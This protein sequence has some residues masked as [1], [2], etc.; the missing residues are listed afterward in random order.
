[1]SE[2]TLTLSC[3]L[4]EQSHE[5]DIETPEGWV[6]RYDGIDDEKAFC[7]KHSVI[8]EFS[9]SNCRGCVGGWGDCDMFRS[10][11]YLYDR[12]ITKDELTTV[13]SGV[14]P[15][16]TN[17]TFSVSSGEVAEIDLSETGTT[18][19]GKAFANA[20]REYMEKYPISDNP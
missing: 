20:I 12:D 4:C 7:P 11:A 15:R 14:C 8:K 6:G 9:E 1:M 17:G 2:Y 3:S 16:R 19:S 5:V 18:E 13:E 10:F